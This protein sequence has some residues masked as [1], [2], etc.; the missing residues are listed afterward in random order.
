MLWW[1]KALASEQ[2]V[3]KSYSQAWKAERE[4]RSL[5]S[6]EKKQHLQTWLHET[7]L[8]RHCM[9]KW[10]SSAGLGER[11]NVAIETLDS[12]EREEH[13]ETVKLSLATVTPYWQWQ[14]TLYWQRQGSTGTQVPSLSADVRGHY[15]IESYAK[16]AAMQMQYDARGRI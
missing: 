14:L 3:T 4:W 1:Q 5:C 9:A 10:Q 7:E 2:R 16:C 11:E 13:T 15:G 8:L 12:V 6:G